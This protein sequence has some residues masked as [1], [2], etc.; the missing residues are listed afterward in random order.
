[1]RPYLLSPSDLELIRTRRRDENRFGLAVHIS[2]L[3]HPG[4]GW[5]DGVVF[6]STLL[7]LLGDQVH[8]PAPHLAKLRQPWGDTRGASSSCAAAS[9]PGAVHQRAY[10][11]G[12][13]YRHDG[14]FCDGSWREDC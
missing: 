4:Q 7:D 2:L 12:G 5:R 13:G 3:R 1:M 9:G 10:G 11:D 14:G 6:P 8:L